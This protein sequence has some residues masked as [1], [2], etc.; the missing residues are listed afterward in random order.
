M[1]EGTDES[2]LAGYIGDPKIPFEPPVKRSFAPWHRPRKQYVRSRQWVGELERMAV[3]I[4][5]EG[6]DFNYL[7]LPGDDLLDVRYLREKFC[8][9]RK[10]NMRFLGFNS[11]ADPDNV[12]SASMHSNLHAIKLLSFVDQISGVIPDDIR[13]IS[14]ERSVA[15]QRVYEF[16]GFHAINLDLCDGFARDPIGVTNLFDA[17]R[18]LIDIQGRTDHDS[19][20]LITTRVGPE[21]V[22][23]D[24]AERLLQGLLEILESCTPF[25]LELRTKWSIGSDL[26]PPDSLAELSSAEQ[27][28]LG[29]SKWVI[30]TCLSA[31]L[32]V[33]VRSVLTYK[34]AYSAS[35]DDLVSIALRLSPQRALP[36]DAAGI[37]VSITANPPAEQECLL[38]AKVPARVWHRRRV[39]EE[40][41]SPEL[42][43][44]CLSE[45]ESMLVAA[46]YDT[47][48]YRAWAS[49]G[50]HT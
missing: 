16:G 9:P 18:V 17:L 23:S 30:N 50:S 35:E 1:P 26:T 38:V 29:L 2:A 5:M 12:H 37:A 34:V 28:I 40:L 27:F 11:A 46:G 13:T 7:S 31:R 19:L 21:H 44:T 39:D 15:R 22:S 49:I 43:E 48:G 25:D 33:A 36:A 24:V 32:D 47:A 6:V 42:L 45:T 10:L 4:G 3:E 8:E 41:R 20:L 14:N